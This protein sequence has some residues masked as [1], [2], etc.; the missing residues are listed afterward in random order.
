MTLYI[1]DVK[2][3]PRWCSVSNMMKNFTCINFVLVLDTVLCVHA[4]LTLIYGPNLLWPTK[5]STAIFTRVYTEDVRPS[6][7]SS[8]SIWNSHKMADRDCCLFLSFIRCTSL[9]NGS[10]FKLRT[11]HFIMAGHGFINH[12]DVMPLAVLWQKLN[13]HSV[14]LYWLMY[15]NK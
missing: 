10:Y 14:G 6:G 3:L 9:T 7:I 4:V 12:K 11:G 8:W 2:P 15:R 5:H 13:I 1:Y